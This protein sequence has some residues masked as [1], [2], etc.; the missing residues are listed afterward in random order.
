MGLS[1][2]EILPNSMDDI[3]IMEYSIH[4]QACPIHDTLQCIS[5]PPYHVDFGIKE[6]CAKAWQ[7]VAYMQ[8]YTGHFI[9][10]EEVLYF[11]DF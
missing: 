5:T 6:I 4:F 10:L 11:G 9:L 2:N 8:C 7:E 1:E 3:S